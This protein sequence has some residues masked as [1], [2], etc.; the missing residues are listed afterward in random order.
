MWLL[1]CPLLQRLASLLAPP[2]LHSLPCG[3]QLVNPLALHPSC[4]PLQGSGTPLHTDVFKSFSW[5]A[6]VVGRKHW[7][8]LP[9]QHAHLLL[10]R[11]G[12]DPPWDF[13]AS[14]DEEEEVAG[15]AA[16][17]GL[18]EARRH[19]VTLVQQPGEAL[20]VPSG[21]FHTGGWVGG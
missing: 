9:P 21:W 4:P 6:N 15:A 13:S 17:P 7:R 8:L 12:R 19:L 14:E 20:F 2:A 11:G 16:F 18:P 3:C 1:D 10:G 5:S